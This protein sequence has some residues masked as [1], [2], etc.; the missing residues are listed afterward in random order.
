MLNKKAKL[1]HFSECMSTS[2]DWGKIW[3]HFQKFNDKSAALNNNVS[4]HN[5][6]NNQRCSSSEQ[7]T[8]NSID[9]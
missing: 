7:I 9:L 3:K 5:I 1:K 8:T 4:E 6:I 2:K